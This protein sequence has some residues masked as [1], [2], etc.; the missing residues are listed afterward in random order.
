MYDGLENIEN[1]S[2]G[3]EV[4]LCSSTDTNL[5]H[6]HNKFKKRNVWGNLSIFESHFLGSS[7]TLIIFNAVIR[8][9][10]TRAT[11]NRRQN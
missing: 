2:P 5:G 4:T 1:P 3:L 9:S 6:N 7:W 10:V 8:I 11:N